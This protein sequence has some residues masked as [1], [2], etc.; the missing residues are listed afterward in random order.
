MSQAEYRDLNRNAAAL[1]DI[2]EC[3]D[4]RIATLERQLAEARDGWNQMAAE[5]ERH[6][7][8]VGEFS[9]SAPDSKGP[10]TKH[11]LAEARGKLDA[12]QEWNK[13][14]GGIVLHVGLARILKGE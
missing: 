5:M 7:C 2:A 13:S 9:C 8:N 12:V 1:V 6:D 11:R 10:C 3:R 4:E 14:F